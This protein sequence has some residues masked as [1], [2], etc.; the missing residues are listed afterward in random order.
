MQQRAGAR[1]TPPLKRRC[2]RGACAEWSQEAERTSATDRRKNGPPQM[3]S[4]VKQ[5]ASRHCS[6]PP[7]PLGLAVCSGFLRFPIARQKDAQSAPRLALT[8]MRS[9]RAEE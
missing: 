8:N 9:Q 2:L 3:G 7:Y 6:P 5:L 1:V 4:A